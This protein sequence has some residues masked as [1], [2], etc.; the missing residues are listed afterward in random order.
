[1]PQAEFAEGIF[2]SRYYF[3]RCHSDDKTEMETRG[4]LLSSALAGDVSN[5]IDQGEN[6]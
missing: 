4:S 6:S 3:E 1:V 2:L 5:G